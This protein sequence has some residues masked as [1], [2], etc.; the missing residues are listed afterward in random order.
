MAV[1]YLPYWDF[2]PTGPV[3]LARSSQPIQSLGLEMRESIWGIDP[4][5]SIPT[6]ISLDEQVDESVARERFQ[7]VILSSFGGAALL[8]AMAGLWW[9][10]LLVAG[11][12][13]VG[14]FAT[15]ERAR[16][17]Q[18]ARSLADPQS[19]LHDIENAPPRSDFTFVVTDPVT[20][21]S[22]TSTTEVTSTTTATSSSADALYFNQVS[23]ITRAAARAELEKQA[24][25]APEPYRSLA[26][27]VAAQLR[28]TLHDGRAR[29]VRS[30]EI[31]NYEAGEAI[32]P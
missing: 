31:G 22:A 1:F 30:P 23:M 11:A 24:S 21:I 6:V 28:E 19:T 27:L 13:V 14:Y 15:A 18:A 29:L 10:A 9:L 26:A 32:P 8:L 5:I 20:P 7:T 25:S 4:E 17:L 3:F 12:G 2:P 16:A